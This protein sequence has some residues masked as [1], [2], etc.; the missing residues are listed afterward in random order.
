MCEISQT[1]LRPWADTVSANR[2]RGIPA[3]ARGTKMRQTAVIGTAATISLLVGF[4]TDT[5]ASWDICNKVAEDMRVAIAY[6]NPAGGF[7]SEGWWTLRSC[8]GCATVLLREETSDPRNVFYRA[9]GRDG[10]LIEGTSQFCVGRSPFK[11]NGQGNC[12]D[13][14]G[15]LHKEIDLDRGWTSNIT[16]RSGSG[17]VCID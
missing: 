4:S 9:E 5:Q 10:S 7:I 12:N 17:S 16:G 6:V 2:I 1:G 8:G 15:F 11:M 14:R 3:Y 13:R